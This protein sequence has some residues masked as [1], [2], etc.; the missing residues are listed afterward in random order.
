MQQSRPATETSPER[1]PLYRF[2]G[3][4]YWGV[5]LGLAFVR[6]VNVLP[7]P[8]Q[9]AIGRGLGRV[10]YLVSRRD[11]RVAAINI[12]M[13][14]P[15]LSEPQREKLVRDH[16]GSL[17]CAILETGLVWWASE[18]RL[19]R[20]IR[21]EGTEH[22]EAAL[23]RG[24]GALML[25]AHFTTLEMG[26]RALTLLG[27]TSVMYMT[28][29]NALIAELSRRS[30]SRHTAQ[31]VT[32]EQIRELLQNLKNNLP[33]WYAPDQ[34]FTDKNSR[35]VP[36]FGQP[37]SSNV[38][39]SRLAKISGAPVLPYFPER[40]RDGSGYIVH[41]Y[42]AWEHFPTDDAIADTQRFHAMIEAHVRKVPEQYLWAYK[43][44][45]RAGFDPYRRES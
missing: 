34:R 26:A 45:R 35:L 4:R 21:F 37:A 11:R 19:R 20:W 9:L 40:K 32:S 27:P 23:A 39:T 10:A 13:C 16:F 38:A 44:F 18:K 30:R 17:G 3:P 31:A 42:A 29:R 15:E 25:S 14:L 1:I 36:F 22:L 33:V 5:W 6:I 12:A 7:L 43:R 28:P 8:L 2:A 41:I 24:R